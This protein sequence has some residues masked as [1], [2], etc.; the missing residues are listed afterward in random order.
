MF[1][2]RVLGQSI[3]ICLRPEVS[4]SVCNGLNASPQVIPHDRVAE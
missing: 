4:P 3:A 2:A 1:Q